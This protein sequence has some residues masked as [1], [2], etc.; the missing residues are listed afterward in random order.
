MPHD[1]R[2][3]NSGQLGHD[4]VIVG[5]SLAG[6]AT[7]ILLGRAGLRVALVEKQPD[8]QAFK[9][10][11][12][13]FIQS[14][15]VPTLNR[16]GLLDPILAAGG[17][18][19]RVRFWTRWGWVEPPSDP[20]ACAVN[21][22]REV[23]DPLVRGAAAATPGV[24]LLLGQSAQS[25]LRDGDAVSGVAVG[26]RH[27][28]ETALRARLVV[29]ADG[30]DSRV[31]ELAGMKGKV[32]PHGRF[33][34][35]AYFRGAAPPRSPDSSA[36]FLDPQWAAAFP[37]DDELVLYAAM[38]TKER[39]PEFKR[40]PAAALVSF[41][42]DLPEAPPILAGEQ[43]GP[44]IG[45]VEMPN[46]MR[47]AAIPG[48]ALA[49]DAALATDPL[50]GIGCGW[51]FQSGEWLA[52]SVAPA[53]QGEEPLERGLKR[54]RRRHASE[55][56]G[57]SFLIHDYATGRRMGLAERLLFSSAARDAKVAAR[58]EELSSRR[59]KPGRTL[60]RILPRAIAVNGR[61]ALASRDSGTSIAGA[62]RGLEVVRG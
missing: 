43:V 52:D 1:R 48:L 60:A 36:W 55:L 11:C 27:G 6:C 46:R 42:A 38:P 56:R 61:H 25:L 39:L 9:R 41:V 13:H 29:G 2:E 19:S 53:L 45:K 59:K 12:G 14:S 47:R 10:V 33:S 7:A 28:N 49:G 17:I 22:R 26:D 50:F 32:L 3:T 23:L 31:A 21:L 20:A 5:A 18:Q 34:Y 57:H 16:L 8:P 4:A 35:G 37:T 30:R 62:D 24:E 51:A 58:F 44:V 15:G 40:D 54:Y